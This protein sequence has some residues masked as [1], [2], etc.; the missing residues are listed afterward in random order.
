MVGYGSIVNARQQVED[1]EGEKWREGKLA[2]ERERGEFGLIGFQFG[3]TSG[4]SRVTDARKG[5]W[6]EERDGEKS[7]E[8]N[9]FQIYNMDSGNANENVYG[10]LCRFEWIIFSIEVNLCLLGK[11]ITSYKFCLSKI[12]ISITMKF[13]NEVINGGITIIPIGRLG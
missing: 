5:G 4:R 10:I 11:R 8:V 6:K 7:K 2:R 12:S 3:V 9:L 1:S 13:I